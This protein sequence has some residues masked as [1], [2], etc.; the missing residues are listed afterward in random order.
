MRIGSFY[1]RCGRLT[2]STMAWA[3]ALSV[4]FCVVPISL[5]FAAGETSLT[6]KAEA[7]TTRFIA[8]HGRHGLIAGYAGESLEGWIY[9]F[10]IFHDYRIG[11]QLEGSSALIPGKAAV[12]KVIINPES[13]TRIYSGGSFTVRETMFVPLNEGGF[14]ILYQVQS[15]SALHIRVSLRPDLDLMWPGGIGGQSYDWDPDRH[16][17][18][19][20][21]SSGKYSALVGS[22]VAIV[23]SAPD[24]YAEPWQ[25]DRRLSFDLSVPANSGERVFPLIASLT[26]Q[27]YYDGAKTYD[28]LLAKTPELYREAV[29]HYQKVLSDGVEV[30]TPDERVNLAYRWARIALD[31]A[32][33]CNPWLGCGLVAGYGPSRDTRRPQYAWFFGGDALENS[34]ALECSG[35]HELARDAIRFVQKYQKKDD[36]EVFHELSQ[37]A[38][39]INWFRDYPYAY[40]H[41][42]ISAFY[43]VAMQNL[44]RAS[45]DTDFLRQSWDSI[46]AAYG[47][48]VTR[49]DS[50]DGL[51]TV[52]AG[53]WGGDETIGQQV[54]KDVYLE[55]V[56]AAGARAFEELAKLAGDGAL[57]DD[58]HRRGEKARASLAAEFWNAKRDFFFYGFNGKGELLTQ[59]LSQPNWG[60]WAD[61]FDAEKS[62]R[63]LDTMARS[64]WESDW[65]VRSVPS[66]DPLYIA[67]SYGHGSVWPL[68][69]GFQSLA[70]YSHHRPL[71]AFP[72]WHAL[73][74]ESFLNSPGHLA[75]VFSGDSDR[76]LDVSVPEQ[77]WSS[78]VV[79]TSL[80]RGLMGL[81]P[82]APGS[83]LRWSP[84][85]PPDWTGV[86][87]R[88]L[89]VGPSTLTLR[90]SQSETG[91]DLKVAASGPP[92]KLTFAP[93]IPLGSGNLRA[94]LDGR[95]VAAGT[96]YAGQDVHAEVTFPTVEQIEVH[97]RWDPGIRPWV[98]PAD[99]E[100]GA[101][102]RGLRILSSKLEGHTYSAQL[103]GPRTRCSRFSMFTPWRV[104]SVKG[105]K[106]DRHQGHEWSFSVSPSPETCHEQ[107]AAEA[108]TT[109]PYQIWTLQV[110]FTPFNR[111][112]QSKAFAK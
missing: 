65:G 63:A 110:E 18:A 86:T 111:A 62:A 98:E 77:I 21:E 22:P 52:P 58:A 41:T 7:T 23:H 46:K 99:L 108:G 50:E 88:N 81:E 104:E 64:R 109:V 27:P 49:I 54:V 29:E 96:R 112:S 42:D 25:A 30:E 101:P 74:E 19:L 28:T 12:R 89:K 44:Y 51:V 107:L 34:F 14:E 100:I 73:V 87:I 66:D 4:A 67:E 103:E 37:S 16:A 85:L 5:P 57:A 32:Y 78:G 94:T 56:W 90:M 38:G 48:L 61:V 55:S 53:G 60:I 76:E 83:S 93:E 92:V 95:T 2:S 75:E 31:Q 33:V 10:R 68:G 106:V 72:L 6:L 105:G 97:L 26:A 79:I 9:P 102:S 8:A 15:L 20:V 84:H 59:E 91:A 70:F 17:F 24:S 13:A 80:M 45:G 39:L 3:L 36:G 71:E 47:Y 11:F 82:D 35:D 40:R 1:R 69:T 43:L